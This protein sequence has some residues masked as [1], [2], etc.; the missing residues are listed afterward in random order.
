M[1]PLTN[2]KNITKLNETELS[3]GTTNKKSWHDMYKESAWVFIGGLP[4]DLTEGD[5]LTVFSQ[6]GEIV[7]INLVRDKKTG[8]T[9][10]FC[11]LC[12]ANQKSTVLAV[13]N[14][15][16]IKICGRTI[17]V[18]HVAN[19]KPPKED[20]RDD[21]LTRTLKAEGC[22]PKPIKTELAESVVKKPKKKKVKKVVKLFIWQNTLKK[23]MW[24]YK[25]E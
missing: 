7:N 10:G 16:G 6:Y 2:V 4:Y 12:Y 24:H 20:E 19:Y 8:K 13:D 22:A 23:Q 21:E 18:D 25:L 15:N 9:K 1:N 14:F 3:A 5:V 17:R 11:F